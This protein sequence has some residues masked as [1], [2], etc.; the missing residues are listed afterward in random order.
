MIALLEQLTRSSG[1][2]TRE[3]A[4]AATARPRPGRPKAF[5]FKYVPAAKTFNLSLKFR[6]S[7][8]DRDEIITALTEIIEELKRA[9]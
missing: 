6:K 2:T 5:T 4:R 8:V 3:Q 7:R 9:D 1:A